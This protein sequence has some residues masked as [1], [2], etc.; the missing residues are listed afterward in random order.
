MNNFLLPKTMKVT[1]AYMTTA[2][3]R[4]RWTILLC[5]ETPKMTMMIMKVRKA[6][7]WGKTK[8]AW[9]QGSCLTRRQG[10]YISVCLTRNKS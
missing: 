6:R 9:T 10:M 5:P 1:L 8:I 2:I 4:L 3:Q 7:K